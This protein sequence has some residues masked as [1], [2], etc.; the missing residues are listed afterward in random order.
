MK[1]LI[2]L[3]LLQLG[4]AGAD[5]FYTNRDFQ[6]GRYGYEGNPIARPFVGSTK[7]RIAYFSASAGLHIGG[8]WLLRRHHRPK[9]ADILLT[10]GIADHAVGAAHNA[11]H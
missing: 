7:G 11:T 4:S 6:S 2:L 10:E 8:A 3:S 1:T 5:A 9:M